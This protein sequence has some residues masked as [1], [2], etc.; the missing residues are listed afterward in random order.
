EPLLDAEGEE[1]LGHD[2]RVDRA[3]LQPG[4]HLRKGEVDVLDIVVF[5]PGALQRLVDGRAGRSAF[6]RLGDLGALE[7]G[8]GLELAAIDQFLAHQQRDISVAGQ[9]RALVGDDLEADPA[10]LGIVEPGRGGG[11]GNVDLAGAERGDHVRPGLHVDQR[12]LEP[13]VLPI[14]F[15]V[16][17]EERRVADHQRAADL[18]LV[19]IGGAAGA[20]ADRRN[21]TDAA[22]EP[23]QP[24]PCQHPG[25]PFCRL[26]QNPLALEREW[27]SESRGWPGTTSSTPNSPRRPI[28][29]RPTGRAPTSRPRCRPR[30]GWRSSAA[31][32]PGCPVRWSS[33]G[34]VSPRWCWSAANSA[35]APAPATAARSAAG[36]MSARAS[37]A[38]P[39]R[40]MPS[41][42]AGCSPTPPMRS[43]WSNG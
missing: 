18:D 38:A 26:S 33:P 36:S 34:T 23:Q 21:R 5:E 29:G 6:A 42:P 7:V 20:R 40:S 22:C 39:P 32:M 1:R 37:A 11:G 9:V 19:E 4:Q 12:D 8:E 41:A 25:L 35:S 17:D 31:A 27:A 28:G 10:R 24:A 30:R 14:P 3:A 43:R 15:V 16:A 2:R 13:L